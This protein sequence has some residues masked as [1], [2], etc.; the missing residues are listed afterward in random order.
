MASSKD[1]MTVVGMLVT[2]QK[3]RIDFFKTNGAVKTSEA[4][5]G[6]LNADEREQ[7]ERLAGNRELPTGVANRDGYITG[8][9][10]A[11]QALSDE[12]TCPSPPCPENDL[13]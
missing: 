10:N 9:K 2:N 5:V 12:M 6:R 7:V 8:V 11:C 13:Y 4:V 1:V 3:F